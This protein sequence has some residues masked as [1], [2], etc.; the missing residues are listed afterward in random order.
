MKPS[1]IDRGVQIAVMRDQVVRVSDNEY[2]VR[3]QSSGAVY[4]VVVTTHGGA[5]SC[6]DHMYRGADCKHIHAVIET[7]RAAWRAWARTAGRL[8]WN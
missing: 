4:D 2:R 5:C 8:P 3:S 7:A 6:P 1:R